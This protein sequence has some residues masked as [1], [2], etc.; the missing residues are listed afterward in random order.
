MTTALEPA[1]GKGSRRSDGLSDVPAGHAGAGAPAESTFRRR[2]LASDIA[3]ELFLPLAVAEWRDGAFRLKRGERRFARTEIT[4]VRY[5]AADP[6]RENPEPER[7]V[8]TDFHRL[9]QSLIRPLH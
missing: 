9:L 7:A 3:D 6:A 4:G 2:M 5:L 1:P 8:Q